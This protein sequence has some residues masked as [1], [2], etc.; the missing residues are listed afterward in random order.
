MLYKKQ[1]QFLL[2]TKIALAYGKNQ[3][4]SYTFAME[5]ERRQFYRHPIK[6]PI[7]LAKIESAAPDSSRT[8]DLSQG[9]LS[10]FWSELLEEGA[11]LLIFIP[12]EK[13]LFKMNAHVAYCRKDDSTG[14]FKT[15]VRFEDSVS[16]FRA[17]LA[18]EILRI[19]QYREKMTHLRGREIS[20][21]EA[22]QLW[23]DRN[24][25]DFADLI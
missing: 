2:Y 9:G 24:A 19:R 17:K 15:G 22:A 7:Q 3:T 20:E 16:A 1:W 18:E 13:Q 5:R 6:V 8:E 10:F 25:K 21:E 11:H 23:I 12:V 4:M 14:L